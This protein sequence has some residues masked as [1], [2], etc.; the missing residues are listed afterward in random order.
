MLPP[1]LSVRALGALTALLLPAWVQAQRIPAAPASTNPLT[2]AEEK[3]L[4]SVFLKSRPGSLR[5]EQCP[6]QGS[7]EEPDGLGSGVV[8]ESGPNGTLALTA[9]HVVFG[10][11]KL[12]AVTVDKSRYPVTVIGYDDGHDVALLRLNVPAGRKLSA[13]PLATAAPKIGQSALAIGNGGGAFLTS[14]TGR[15]TALNVAAERADFPPGTLELTSALVPGDSGG[16]ILNDKGEVMGV[17]SYISLRSTALGVATRASYAV[18]VTKNS[19]LL[20][21]LRKGVKRDAPVIGLLSSGDIAEQYFEPLGLG[22]LSGA[23]FT[24]VTKGGPADKAGL[25]PI[26]P[27]SSDAYGTPTKLGGDVI[28]AI[29]GVRIHGFD[30]LLSAVRAR[31]VGEIIKLSV[32]R[33]GKP[34]PD[35]NLTLGPRTLTVDS[36]R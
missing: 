22:N 36:Q 29:N 27:L 1:I 13:L 28:T 3:S 32:V 18:P 34:I 17:V 10:A 33:D 25:K 24:A 23:V 14:K 12:E 7:C 8:I 19:S 30:E 9:Y 11:K 6:P 5:I 35:L 4:G 31:Q 21:D 16:P 20:A 15:L 26:R 2:V